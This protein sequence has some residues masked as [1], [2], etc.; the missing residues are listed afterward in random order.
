MD[1]Q[2]GPDRGHRRVGREPRGADLRAGQRARRQLPVRPSGRGRLG[3]RG[4][5]HRK[6]GDDDRGPVD[7]RRLAE[8]LPRHRMDGR[9]AARGTGRAGDAD[10]LQLLGHRRRRRH[11]ER[12]RARTALRVARGAAVVHRGVRR[13][14]V[15]GQPR[16]VE[17]RG[18][19]REGRLQRRD[20]VRPG[21]GRVA[22]LRVGDRRSQ[23]PAREPGERCRD[24]RRGARTP[25]ADDRGSD[26]RRKVHD[27]HQRRR[28]R[29][30]VAR[31]QRHGG[32]LAA[33]VASA[34]ARARGRDRVG[35][36]W[37]RS[38]SCSS[39]SSSPRS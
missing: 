27:E 25:A 17:R 35:C 5:R 22:G 31:H 19:A 39:C 14:P 3:R 36:S 18:A 15:T 29:R 21:S 13:Q 1:R 8:R 26:R 12:R 37:R 9:R 4:A 7:R 23:R 24:T 6:G 10:V 2:R 11:G 28:R 38:S 30:P 16:G 20:R 34:S 32:R 33:A